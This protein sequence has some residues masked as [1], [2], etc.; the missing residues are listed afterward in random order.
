M[1]DQDGNLIGSI[2]PSVPI[3]PFPLNI[4]LL[5][6]ILGMVMFV[7]PNI[8]SICDF[9]KDYDKHLRGFLK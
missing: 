5:F 4:G 7:V 6:V 2:T 8:K 1:F 9:Y 3:W